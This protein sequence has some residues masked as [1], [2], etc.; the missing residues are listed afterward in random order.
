M[1]DE[2]DHVFVGLVNTSW[3]HYN[4]ETQ[5]TRMDDLLVGAVIA[6]MV[7]Q[8]WSLI[9]LNSD[10]TNHYLRFE[11]LQ[12]RQRVIFQL[13]N[14][15][16]DLVTAKV[17]GRR[18]RVTIGYGEFVQNTTAV[19]AA[20][21][22]EMKSGFLDA[23]EP[24]VITCDADLTASYIYVQVPLILDLDQYF[25]QGWQVN[26]SL[27]QHH[28]TASIQALSKYLRGRLAA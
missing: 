2:L 20:L 11:W 27:L 18:A 16:E 3:K 8:G 25:A 13:R 24:G 14:L 22:A 1:S 9:D 15:S 6:S 7:E 17:L 21:K 26:Y 28:L 10:G 19:W 5:N 12:T 23:A 4:E